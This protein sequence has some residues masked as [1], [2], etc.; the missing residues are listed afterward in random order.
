MPICR[1]FMWLT[2]AWVSITWVSGLRSATVSRMPL[3]FRHN[4]KIAFRIFYQTGNSESEIPECAPMTVCNRIDTYSTPWIERQCRCPGK[5]V[6]SMSLDQH[7]GHTIV[8][9]SRQ[10][11]LCEPVSK[12]PL[13]RYFRDIT[14]TYISHPNNTTQQTIHCICPKN[15]VAYIY[16]HQ[17]YQTSSGT[18]YKYSFVCSPQSRLKCQRKEPC[19]LFTVKKR[20]DVEVVNTN[21]LCQCPHDHQCPG[22]HTEPSVI[23]EATYPQDHIRT[24]SGYCMQYDA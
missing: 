3:N 21:T 9:K 5:H 12:L 1:K 23:A 10:F 16:K 8:D 7:D 18:G 4:H 22:H 20:P 11:K 17:L 24:Y 19:R 6:C 13:C 15:S 14:W 2:L